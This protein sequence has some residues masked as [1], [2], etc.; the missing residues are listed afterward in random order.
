M[1]RVEMSLPSSVLEAPQMP[2]PQEDP[3]GNGE[4]QQQTDVAGVLSLNVA[5]QDS[6]IT[7]D[8]NDAQALQASFSSGGQNLAHDSGDRSV[9]GI[10]PQCKVLSLLSY[11]G[12][13]VPI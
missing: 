13:N 12:A 10:N 9:Q 6:D 3:K 7:R 8:S 11:I 5:F 2:E 4:E 1:F